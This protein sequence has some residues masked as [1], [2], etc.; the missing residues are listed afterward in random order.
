M[1]TGPV[2]VG[3]ISVVAILADMAAK[4]S[5][6]SGGGTVGADDTK[7]KEPGGSQQE[8]D[9]A[10]VAPTA[11][12]AVYKKS[13]GKAQG[14]AVQR[15]TADGESPSARLKYS[16]TAQGAAVQR[17]T[18]AEGSEASGGATL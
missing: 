6:A 15:A 13:S 12:R 3:I 9:D 14:A 16:F 18:A 11:S 2:L 4:G 8:G 5:D 10:C 7:S 17:T 1:T